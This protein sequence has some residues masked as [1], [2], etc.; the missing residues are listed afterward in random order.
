MKYIMMPIIRLLLRLF[1]TFSMAILSAI[2]YI[3]ASFWEGESMHKLFT[4]CKMKQGDIFYILQP[5]NKQI[6]VNY[7]E[8]HTQR[9]PRFVAIEWESDYHF[10]WGYKP[11]NIR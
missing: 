10:I 8:E 4:G 1:L 9:N 3:V 11:I 5:K 7:A 6:V 2:A